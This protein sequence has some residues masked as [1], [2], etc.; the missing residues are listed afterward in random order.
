MTQRTFNQSE[1]PYFVTFNVADR[2]WVFDDLHLAERLNRT[3]RNACSLKHFTLYAFCILPDHV[4]LLVQKSKSGTILT[5]RVFITSRGSDISSRVLEKTRLD[6]DDIFAERGLS[7]PR[8]VKIHTL[9]N[10]LQSIKG[11]FSYALPGRG[12]FWQPRSY[13][14]IV[15]SERYLRNV[16]V[17]IQNNYRKQNLPEVPYAF[18]P[19]V[20]VDEKAVQELFGLSS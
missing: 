2:K 14:R 7:R 9:S 10:L 8:E 1:F 19:Y 4:H 13:Y 16:L 5:S 17:Y 12:R 15:M 20:F 11:N 18:P 6:N 3:I